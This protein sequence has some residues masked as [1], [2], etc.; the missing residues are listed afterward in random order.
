[1]RRVLALALLGLVP[2]TLAAEHDWI[3]RI[4]PPYPDGLASSIGA[5]VG[6]GPSPDDLCATSI[7]T[8]EDA[9]GR[10]LFL[11]GTRAAGHVDGKPL[12][13]ITDVIAAPRLAAGESLAIAAC[14]RGGEPD[15]AVVAVV[16]TQGA[17][18]MYETVRWAVR[19]EQGRFTTLPTSGLRCHNEG[20]GE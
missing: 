10:Q 16:D 4:V 7:A 19:L 9:D 5:C 8:L 6:E 12:W 14:E 18:E 2:P 17:A 15:A 13:M 11:I 1:M 20:Y 3:G